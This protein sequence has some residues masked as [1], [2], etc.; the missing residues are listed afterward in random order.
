[1]APRHYQAKGLHHQS[2]RL[3]L[4]HHHQPSLSKHHG[5]KA[6]IKQSSCASTRPRGSNRV[7]HDHHDCTHRHAGC[8]VLWPLQGSH[9]IVRHKAS[10]ICC[11]HQWTS[12]NLVLASMTIYSQQSPPLSLMTTTHAS[13]KSM[14]PSESFSPFGINGKGSSATH[15]NI[16]AQLPVKL[17]QHSCAA[18]ASFGK[19]PWSV[20]SLLRT[21]L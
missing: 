17:S 16:S 2:K 8:I 6:M 15:H 13:P 14:L 5:S 1:M 10:N 7:N 9:N 4:H 21:T 3:H 12:Y 19:C 20:E 11:W 18:S